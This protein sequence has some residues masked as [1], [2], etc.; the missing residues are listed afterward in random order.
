MPADEETLQACTYAQ[1]QA[2]Q[3]M[4]YVIVGEARPYQYHYKSGRWYVEVD[5]QHHNPDE[6]TAVALYRVWR[7][8]SGLSAVRVDIRAG[9]D[10]AEPSPDKSR[11]GFDAADAEEQVRQ[12]WSNDE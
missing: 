6:G 3:D 4:P 1:R 2:A 5:L 7:T 8:A 10:E 11:R 12:D 9:A